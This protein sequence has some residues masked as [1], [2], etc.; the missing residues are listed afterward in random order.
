L[1]I[2]QLGDV[3]EKVLRKMVRNAWERAHEPD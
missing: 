1:Y 3:D 2:R